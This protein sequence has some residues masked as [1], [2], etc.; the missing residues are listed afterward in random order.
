MD[1]RLEIL[2]DYYD[3]DLIDSKVSCQWIIMVVTYYF[4]T[5]D[6]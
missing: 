2:L 6:F 5:N 3:S 4:D 1:R